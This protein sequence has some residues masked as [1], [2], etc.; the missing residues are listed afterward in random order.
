MLSLHILLEIVIIQAHMLNLI[1]FR[2]FFSQQLFELILTSHRFSM[3]TPDISYISVKYNCFS[4]LIVV[5]SILATTRLEHLL[6][7]TTNIFFI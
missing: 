1:Y 6:L 5:V 7:G 2:F 3:P 4:V